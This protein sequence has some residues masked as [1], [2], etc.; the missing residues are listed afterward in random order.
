VTLLVQP[1]AAGLISGGYVY[2]ARMATA[3]GPR[4]RLVEATD[5]ELPA[6][7]ATRPPGEVALVDSLYLAG[8]AMPQAPDLVLLAHAMPGGATVPATWRAA[9]CPSRYAAATVCARYPGLTTHVCRPGVARRGAEPLPRGNVLELVTVANLFPAKGHLELVQALASLGDAAFR[10]T[11]VGDERVDPV[12]ARAVR[13]AVERAGL[14][15]RTRWLG[16]LAPEAVA[17]VV[18][19]CHVLVHPS[20]AENYGMVLAEALALGRPVVACAVGGVPE[21]VRADVT[22][23][24]VEPGSPRAL[25]AAVRRLHDDRMLLERLHRACAEAALDIPTWPEAARA[26]GRVLD[27]LEGQPS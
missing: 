27:E 6:I 19:S 13:A 23:L 17:A 8:V 15:S 20:R 10:W 2:N 26:L 16:A 9:V 24:L 18:A 1:P 25:A 5:D 3:L 21:V 14:A 12:Q 11:L 4:L 7:L 22:G